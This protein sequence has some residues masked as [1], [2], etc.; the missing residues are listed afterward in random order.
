VRLIKLYWPLSVLILIAALA[1]FSD[2]WSPLTKNQIVFYFTPQVTCLLACLI[3][4]LSLVLTL[5]QT[6]RLLLT[7]ASS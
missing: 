7:S 1:C 2:A 4:P 3:V 6:R 5:V